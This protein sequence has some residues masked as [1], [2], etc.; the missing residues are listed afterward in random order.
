MFEMEG[1]FGKTGSRQKAHQDREELPRHV[2]D[3]MKLDSHTCH[4]GVP[5][6]NPIDPEIAEIT[7]EDI[8]EDFSGAGADCRVF[9]G[10]IYI[11]D[12]TDALRFRDLYILRSR[13]LVRGKNADLCGY[14][15]QSSPKI[16][17]TG[18]VRIDGT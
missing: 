17:M 8:P 1:T 9:D 14:E 15:V 2:G 12:Q 13:Q 7:N 5:L 11:A 18:F 3:I 6:L 16:E 4:L 10:I